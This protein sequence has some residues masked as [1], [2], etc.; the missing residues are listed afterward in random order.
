VG[1]CVITS[2]ESAAQALEVLQIAGEKA[3]RLGEVIDVGP[4]VEFEERVRFER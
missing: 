3:F 4:G 2:K 1:L